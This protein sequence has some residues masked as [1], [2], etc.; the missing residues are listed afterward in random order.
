MYIKDF[1]DD[2]KENQKSII[3][4]YK[5]GNIYNNQL[6]TYSNKEKNS[7]ANTKLLKLLDYSINNF[8]TNIMYGGGNKKIKDFK[9][10]VKKQCS[11]VKKLYANIKKQETYINKKKLKSLN[12]YQSRFKEIVKEGLLINKELNKLK[13]TAFIKKA[14]I[15]KSINRD[16]KASV[17]IDNLLKNF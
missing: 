15:N 5:G 10:L 4:M 2:I 1:Y 6:N 7:V 8:N 16:N 9:K 3:S 14:T 17:L 11:N 13:A 12:L